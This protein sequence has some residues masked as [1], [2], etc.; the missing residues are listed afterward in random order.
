MCR[1]IWEHYSSLGTAP[2]GHR[3][4]PMDPGPQQKAK[5]WRCLDA[6]KCTAIS[7]TNRGPPPRSAAKM[8]G[9]DGMGCHDSWGAVGRPLDEGPALNFS[10][11]TYDADVG[12]MQDVVSPPSPPF[13]PHFKSCGSPCACCRPKS[14]GSPCAC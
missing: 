5:S 9:N 8:A 3:R 4:G 6:D 11:M 1:Q 2:D 10:I 13:P 12:E 14:L 7:C